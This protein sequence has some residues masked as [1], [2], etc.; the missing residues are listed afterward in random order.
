MRRGRVSGLMD[1]ADNNE[2]SAHGL[3]VADKEGSIRISGSVVNIRLIH[4]D[5]AH[6][7]NLDIG[8][9][10]RTPQL[11]VSDQILVS[12]HGLLRHGSEYIR[13]LL[14]WLCPEGHSLGRTGEPTLPGQSLRLD[15]LIMET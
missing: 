1:S 9:H 8:G 14:E 13:R 3:A 15:I 10:S 5:D 6:A 7:R 2:P 11:C 12:D 4:H